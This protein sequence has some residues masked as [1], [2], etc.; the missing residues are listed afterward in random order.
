MDLGLV[1]GG[2]QR[3]LGDAGRQVGQRFGRVGPGRPP[4]QP[5]VIGE[6]QALLGGQRPEGEAGVGLRLGALEPDREVEGDGQVDEHVEELR[7]LL[8]GP[9]VGGEVG[10]VEPPQH[11]PLHLGPALPADLVQVGVVPQVLDRPGEAPVAVEEAGSAGEGPPAEPVELGVE[12]EMHAQVLAPVQL[13][14]VPGPGPGHDHGAGGGRAL[15]DGPIP[16][17]GRGVGGADPVGADDHELGAGRVAEP[18][19]QRVHGAEST[20]PRYP[21]ALG[22][23]ARERSVRVSVK[24]AGCSSRP[25]P[26]G[27]IGPE[28]RSVRVSEGACRARRRR[29]TAPARPSGPGP[30]PR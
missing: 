20:G 1:Q 13:G 19:G 16:A 7:P 2:A 9:Q 12:G 28:K 26:P 17:R 18:L 6:D 11:G 10:H 23:S 5:E 21:T 25:Q 14:R 30:R 15:P 22:E 24:A 8:H 4:H 29:P 3:Q 27:H